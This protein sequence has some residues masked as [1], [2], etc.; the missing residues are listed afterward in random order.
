MRV[1]VDLN[2][3]DFQRDFVKLD[4]ENTLAFRNTL[5]KLLRLEWN[6]VYRDSG[7]NWELILGQPK[8]TISRLY[9]IRVTQKF[10][11]VVSRQDSWLR[12]HELHP[13]HDGAYS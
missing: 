12:F 10:R 7:L 1:L 2:D 11:A 4:N 3:A 5:R 13:D 9:S 8:D 6:Q